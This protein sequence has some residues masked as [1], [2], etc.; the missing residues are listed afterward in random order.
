MTRTRIVLLL[1]IPSLVVL[2]VGCQNGESEQPSA[3]EEPAA[4]EAAAGPEETGEAGT[5]PQATGV[6]YEPAYPTDVSD[7]GLSEEDAAQQ[8]TTHSHDGGEEHAHGEGEDHAHGEGDDDHA[9]DD[10][11]HDDHR[12]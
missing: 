3:A 8:Q 10:G 7:E 4:A 2:S 1:S 5:E 12:H 11:S 6:T 9:H